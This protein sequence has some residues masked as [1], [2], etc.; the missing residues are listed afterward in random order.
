MRYIQVRQFKQPLSRGADF[1]RLLVLLRGRRDLLECNDLQSCPEAR[2]KESVDLYLDM[3]N[4][5][6]RFGHV[7]QSFWDCAEIDPGWG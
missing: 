3:F 7:G 5:R 4:G 1:S 2:Q 6:I